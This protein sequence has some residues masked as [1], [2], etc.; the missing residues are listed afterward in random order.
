MGGG[1]G[2]GVGG[3]C[4]VCEEGALAAGDEVHLWFISM[5]V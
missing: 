2:E 5:L 1:V 4:G 3:G